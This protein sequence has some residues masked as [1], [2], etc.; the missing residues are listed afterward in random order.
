[1]KLGELRAAIRKTKGNPHIN[2]YPWPGTDKGL[3]IVAQK[4]ELL[5]ELE[6]VYPG[7]K[8]TETGMEFVE[9]TG[10][11]RCV[12]YDKSVGLTDT[13][14]AVAFDGAAAPRVDPHDDDDLLDLDSD[15]TPS[16]AAGDDLDDLLV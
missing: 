3:R 16:T 11:L 2:I 6:R 12:D 14:K 10:M 13:E 15:P 7:G 4:T 9:N 8:S 1:M 5:K